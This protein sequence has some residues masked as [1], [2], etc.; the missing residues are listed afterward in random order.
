MKSLFDLILDGSK[1]LVEQTRAHETRF[2]NLKMELDLIQS[3]P[4]EAKEIAPRRSTR[5]KDTYKEK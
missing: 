2:N 3:Q 5:R 1:D 4:Q